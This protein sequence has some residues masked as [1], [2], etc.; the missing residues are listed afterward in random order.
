MTTLGAEFAGLEQ[1]AADCRALANDLE[2]PAPVV[3]PSWQATAAA[4]QTLHD[5][6]RTAGLKLAAR[7]HATAAAVSVAAAAYRQHETG[8]SAQLV[9]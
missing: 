6:V 5:E 8:A 2:V 9:R 7:L 4:T 3:G 1:L